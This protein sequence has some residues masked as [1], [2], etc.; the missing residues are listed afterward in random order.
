MKK[1]K[2]VIFGLLMSFVCV[3]TVNAASGSINASTSARTVA[4]G[5]TFT[6]TV[7][8][9]S[10]EALGSWKF[11]ISYDSSVISL[12]SG[13]TTIAGYGDGAI[14]SKTYTYKFK[15]I[16]SGTASV[17]VMSP[18]MVSWANP[19]ELFT[20]SSSNVSVSVKTQAEIQASYSKDN[21]LKSLTVE[22]YE[23]SPAF[24]KDTLEYSVSVPDTV[25]KIKVVAQVNDSTARVS[26]TGEIELSQGINKVQVVVTAQN[27]SLKTYT[28][29][30]DVKDLNPIE[31][32]IDGSKYTVV[33]KPELLTEPIGHTA[34][35]IKIGEVDVPGFKSELTHLVIVGLK[36]DNGNIKMFIYD[37]DTGKYTPYNEIKNASIAL[38]P[39][40]T[41]NDVEGFKRVSLKINDEK[42]E[43]FQS[44]A[45]DDFYLLF[46]MNVA[47]GEEDYYI[48]DDENNLFVKY[49][50]KV[51]EKVLTENK[52]FKLYTFAL[53][54]VAI[55]LFLLVIVVAS[56][57]SKFKKI[58]KRLSSQ[59]E[60][61]RKVKETV[62]EEEK[63]EMKE[64]EVTEEDNNLE[65]D[66][67]S[68]SKKDEESRQSENKKKRKKNNK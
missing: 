2:K 35:T 30:I 18:S 60:V 17:K 26:G 21:N 68:E 44:E 24:D 39:V 59:A 3:Y 57:N 34:A 43:A 4:V 28:I 40:K 54:G 7:K 10:G 11:G 5:S 14:K 15:A 38:L 29:S 27:G 42:Y 32:D 31:V 61:K 9:S 50:S 46:A 58:I 65:N 6:V 48:F 64:Q 22:G 47:T 49:N 45:D 52:E 66:D 13:D 37:E 12:Q 55:V 23:L 20:P 16:K 8:V 63:I 36:D 41:E 51:F 25:E 33:K 19:N 67:S 53:G 62:E 1:I 56:K